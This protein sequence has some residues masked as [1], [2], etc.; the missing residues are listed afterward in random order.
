MST[1]HIVSAAAAKVSIGA[2]GGNRIGVMLRRGD[3]VPQGVAE[4]QLERLVGRGLIE[5]V[6]V[7]EPSAAETA[8]TQETVEI[9]E[10]DPSEEWT[11]KQLDAYAAAKGIDLGSGKNK[12]EKLA[13]IAAASA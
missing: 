8:P 4:E 11:A 7:E 6:E 1:Q 10:G 3:I 2:A 9:P 5:A 12:A 13:A